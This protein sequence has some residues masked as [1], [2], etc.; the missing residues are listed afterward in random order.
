MRCHRFYTRVSR[1]SQ[2]SS[3]RGRRPASRRCELYLRSGIVR[4]GAA[5]GRD[6]GETQIEQQLNKL[7]VA[8]LTEGEGLE[9]TGLAGQGQIFCRQQD[10]LRAPAVS[11]RLRHSGFATADCRLQATTAGRRVGRRRPSAQ[12]LGAESVSQM[13][14]LPSSAVRG[15]FAAGATSIRSMSASVAANRLIRARPMASGSIPARPVITTPPRS[16]RRRSSS[17][18]ASRCESAS[19]AVGR[20]RAVAERRRALGHRRIPLRSI[21]TCR[22]HADFV[23]TSCTQ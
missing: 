3:W 22:R 9:H 1:R 12:R 8:H 15:F 21:A 2:V 5:A 20:D 7:D 11:G 19:V 23:P 10:L 17:A 16:L 18:C 4:P 13:L 14:F 6:Q